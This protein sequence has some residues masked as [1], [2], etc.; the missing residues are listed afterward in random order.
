MT[1]QDLSPAAAANAD[2]FFNA[3]KSISDKF[4]FQALMQA[5]WA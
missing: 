2:R 5:N 3:I 1:I 4:T